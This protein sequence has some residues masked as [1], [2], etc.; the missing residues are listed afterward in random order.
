[1]RIA[2]GVLLVGICG[3]AASQNGVPAVRSGMVLWY[4]QPAA[5]WNAALPVGNGR[6]GAMVFGGGNA[7]GPD[8]KLNNGDSQDQKVNAELLGGKLTRGQDEHLQVNESTVWAGDRGDR[9]NPKAGAAFQEMRRLMLAGKVDEAEALTGDAFLSEPKGMPGYETLGDIYLRAKDGAPVTEYRRELDLN[10]GLVRV[11]YLQS[12]THF[13]R[14]VFA[15]AAEKV[16]VVRVTADRPGKV[17]FEV[18]MDRASDF[19]TSVVGKERLLMVPGAG[20]VEQ[21]KWAAEVMA[22]P[23]GGSMTPEGKTLRVAG[24]NAVTLLFAAATDFKGGAFTGGD[25]VAADEAVLKA[26]GGK[27]VGAMKVAAAADL[28]RLM[29]AAWLQLGS[30]VDPLA[31]LPTDERIARASAG[32]PDLHL[33]MIYFQMGRYLLAQ[34]SRPGGMAANLQGLWASEVSNPWGSKYTVNANTEMNYWPADVTGLGETEAPLFDLIDRV[35]TPGS[36]TGVEVAR[37][38]YGAGGFVLHHNTDIWGDANPIDHVWAGIWPVG[39]AWMTLQMWDHYGYTRDMDFLRTR[40]YPVLKQ[41]SEFFAD[42]LTDDGKGHLVTGPSMSPENRYKLPD[43]SAHS[44]VM[45]PTMDIEITRE[46]LSRTIEAS[47]I[48]GV[49]AEFRAK[50]VGMKAKL[51]PFQIGKLGN[52]QE[53]PEDYAENE[54]GH[55][56]ISHLWALYPGS[57][58][59]VETTPDLARAARVTLERRLDHGGGQTGWS[60]AWVIN[61]W[62]RLRDGEKAYES[63]QVLLKQSTFVDLLDDHPPGVFQIDGNEGAVAGMAGMV[64]DSRFEPA[65]DGKEMV[66]EV[67]FL[68]ALPKEWA[69]G[70]CDGFR[71]RGGETV[72][73]V[74]AGGKAVSATLV[75]HA[76]GVLR[77]RAPVGQRIGAVTSGGKKVAVRA[78]GEVVSFLQKAGERYELV[79]E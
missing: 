15:N 37:K 25:P 21:I 16:I 51:L 50:L 30:A 65:A 79:F 45:G 2:A 52:I 6:L 60:R 78:E 8:G 9:L 44:L 34:S 77:L 43:G 76:D 68:P 71:A 58:I 31:D 42:Y 66:A 19:E 27:E 69:E 7:A 41:A 48:L 49:D 61:Y 70:S 63:L 54:V 73:M 75:A 13:V 56:H 22:L 11:S 12:G 28:Q 46:L 26:V 39:G 53:W 1:M 74:W 20:H 40:A 24:A 4:K 36:G 47:E 5:Q 35:R 18:G 33:E 55:R 67:D 59:T 57:Q 23:T 64:M 3:G 38:Y 29:G 72:T 32:K 17:S 14:E 10:T 62:D